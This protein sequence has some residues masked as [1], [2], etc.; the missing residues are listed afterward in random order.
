MPDRKYNKKPVCPRASKNI[1][2]PLK[3]A[4]PYKSS[5]SKLQVCCNFNFPALSVDDVNQ[6]DTPEPETNRAGNSDKTI[7]RDESYTLALFF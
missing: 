3:R 1:Q 6:I 4:R 2:H 7:M 5:Q